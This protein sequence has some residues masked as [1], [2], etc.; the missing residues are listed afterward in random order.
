MK[1]K[2]FDRIFELKRLIHS[3]IPINLKNSYKES[4]KLFSRIYYQ[5]VK[6]TQQKL[7]SYIFK[8]YPKELLLSFS[9]KIIYLLNIAIIIDDK[10]SKFFVLRCIYYFRHLENY[11]KAFEDINRAIILDEK[12]C[13]YYAIRAEIR[14][15]LKEYYNALKDI[16]RAIELGIDVGYKVIR[17][18]YVS[19][20]KLKRYMVCQKNLTELQNLGSDYTQI[21]KECRLLISNKIKDQIFQKPLC[22]Y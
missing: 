21:V 2:D 16:H 11:D 18:K 12:F 8:G 20:Y 19:N 22:K 4:L 5:K 15:E 6:T 17:I 14:L 1:L 9:N 13:D 3:N 10:N 7:S